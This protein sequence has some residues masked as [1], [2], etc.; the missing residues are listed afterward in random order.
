MVVS[1]FNSEDYYAPVVYEAL[2]K[3]EAKEHAA[4]TIAAYCPWVLYSHHMQEVLKRILTE[5]G[6]FQDLQLRRT[7]FQWCT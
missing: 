4:R 6:H 1:K 7:A 2:T 5:P 3:V